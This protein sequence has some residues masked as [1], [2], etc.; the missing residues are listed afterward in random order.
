MIVWIKAST[1]G[2]NA[3][4]RAEIIAVKSANNIIIELCGTGDLYRIKGEDICGVEVHR[5]LTLRFLNA[6][7]QFNEI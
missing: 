1:L 6:R 4:Q 3:D 7:V 2:S 5:Q